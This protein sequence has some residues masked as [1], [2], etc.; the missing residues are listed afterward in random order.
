MAAGLAKA[1]VKLNIKVLP[2]ATLTSMLKKWAID[3]NPATAE[4]ASIATLAPRFPDP[5]SLLFMLYHSSA[6]TGQGRNY[7]LYTN[8]KVDEMVAKAVTIPDRKERMET[9]K[10]VVQVATDDCPDIFVEKTIDRIITRKVLKGYY[11]DPT[12]PKI[13]PYFDLYKVGP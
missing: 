3:R 9:Y 4:N 13:V 1:G 8:P 10:K 6:Q 11:F 7:M 2:W 5:Y 12:L